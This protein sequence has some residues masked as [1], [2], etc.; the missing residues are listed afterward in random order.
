MA[1]G[2]AS[3]LCKTADKMDCI[4]AV[5][6]QLRRQVER[7]GTKTEVR[8]IHNGFVPHRFEAAVEKDPYAMIQV[9]HLIPSKRTEI[10]VRAFAELKKKYPKL[11]LKIIGIGHLR[12]ALEELCRQLKVEDAVTFTGQLPNR[13]VAAAMQQASYFVMAS[14]PEGFGIVYLEAMAAGCVTVGTQEQGIADVIV[15]GE[16]G[17]LVPADDVDAVV[18]VIDRCLTDPEKRDEIAKNAKT[19]AAGMTWTEN[20]EKYLALFRKLLAAFRGQEN[21]TGG[22]PI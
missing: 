22:T 9:G 3:E 12:Q 14:K 13:D 6:E 21:Q 20:A 7:C 8:C 11:T 18:A 17:F 2:K 19:L 16:N 10:T 4:V 15:D 5:S 1:N